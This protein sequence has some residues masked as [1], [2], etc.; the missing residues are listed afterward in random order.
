MEANGCVNLG[1]ITIKKRQVLVYSI[2]DCQMHS[3]DVNVDDWDKTAM[4]AAMDAKSVQKELKDN[5][6]LTSTKDVIKFH[7][8]RYEV[9]EDAFLN[10]LSQTIGAYGEPLQ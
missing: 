9:C 10:L 6:K 3:L 7:P 2:K 4:M 8:D 5:E 1:T